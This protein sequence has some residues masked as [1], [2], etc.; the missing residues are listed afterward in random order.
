[1]EVSVESLGAPVK[2]W[3]TKPEGPGFQAAMESLKLGFGN[4]PLAIG[5][6]GTIGFVEPLEELLGGVP[7][8]LLGIED[9]Q[10]N[11]HAPNESL[12]EADW[13]SLIKSMVHL[14]HLY[15]KSHST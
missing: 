1:M 10:S 2:W 6:G 15:P 4:E 5:C 14:I 9:P 7:S 11:A 3:L 8:L 12:H 13:Y